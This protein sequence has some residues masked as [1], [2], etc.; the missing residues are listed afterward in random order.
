MS[1]PFDT[2]SEAIRRLI[3][4]LNDATFDQAL[5][6]TAANMIQTLEAERDRFAVDA[7]HVIRTSSSKAVK[8]VEVY[9]SAL[10]AALE[11]AATSLET[12]ARDGARKGTLLE[13]RLQI[14]G[15]ANS[16]ARSARSA[17]KGGL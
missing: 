7:A 14:S 10:R 13:D 8:A 1:A 15:Y 2:S 12:I 3:R 6:F 5:A 4:E 16:R 17:A 11:D 9:L